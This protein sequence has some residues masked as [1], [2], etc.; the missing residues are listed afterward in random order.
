MPGSHR[1]LYY[2]ILPANVT[3]SA[4]LVDILVVHG[5]AGTAQSD[6]AGLLPQLQERQ[7]IVAPELYGYGRSTHRTTYPTSYY[8][9]DVEDLKA[10]LD[11]LKLS[12]VQV[13]AFSDGGIVGLLLAARY[14]ERIQ[15]LAVLG[16]QATLQESDV[17]AIRHWLLER[18]LAE[19]WQKELAKLHG[20]PYWRS[21]PEMYVRV[22]EELV[23]EG[24]ELISKQ[25]LANI[26]CPTL[27][28]HG[29]RDRVVSVEYAYQLHKQIA[30]AELRLF[31]AGHAAHL[32]CAEEYTQAVKEFLRKHE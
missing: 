6:F 2:D 13:V 8:G 14:P 27:I 11:Q 9:D 7:N 32:R 30:G 4:S 20:D 17:S 21:L 10:L 3:P 28:M 16:A 18:P 31:E 25:E 22:Q 26:Q 23:A 29:K 24:G 1:T 12:R 5:F 15:A 19:E